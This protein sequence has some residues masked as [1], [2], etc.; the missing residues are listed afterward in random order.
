MIRILNGD[1][2]NLRIISAPYQGREHKIG[3]AQFKCTHD[4]AAC[5]FCKN[6]FPSIPY[7]ILGCIDRAA[8]DLFMWKISFDLFKELRELAR[9]PDIGDPQG[10]D[11]ELNRIDEKFMVCCKR[12][13]ELTS[14][15]LSL[16][17][18]L[19]I[20]FLKNYVNPASREE[21]DRLFEKFQ[22]KLL[23]LL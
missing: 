11:I 22:N 6:G 18:R 2:Y 15:D 14:Q 19:D 5:L 7:W 12:K 20:D 9:N 17:E 16:K 23:V 1:H 3:N 21:M 8:N 10:Y 4:P 13:T